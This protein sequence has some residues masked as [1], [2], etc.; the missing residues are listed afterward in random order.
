MGTKADQ[1]ALEAYS[2]IAVTFQHGLLRLSLGRIASLQSAIAIARVHTDELPERDDHPLWEVV[3]RLSEIEYSE[4]D[5][6]CYITDLSDLV[7][8]TAVFDTFLSETTRF[9]FLRNPAALGSDCQ[10]PLDMVLKARSK[11]DVLNKL[12]AKKTREMAYLSLT[13]RMKVLRQRFGL[14]PILPKGVREALGDFSSIRNTVLHDQG[15][16]EIKIDGRGRLTTTQRACLRHPTPITH[17]DLKR[18]RDAYA[19]AVKEI[20][21]AVFTQV[22]R[23]SKGSPEYESIEKLLEGGEE[24]PKERVEQPGATV[25]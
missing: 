24:L 22:L 16:F 13:E 14:K 17:A 4:F 7:Y 18:A 15:L 10:V 21:K 19:R 8:A 1:A 23:V 9:L 5:S 20:A 12:V 11:P 6:F 25:K 2:A 3:D